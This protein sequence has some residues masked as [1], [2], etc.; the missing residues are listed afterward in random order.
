MN[1]LI[2]ENL[3][4]EEGHAKLVNCLEKFNIY[5]E[6]ISVLP[7]IDEVEFKTTDK[8]VFVFGSLKL[9]RLSKKYG[10]EPGA[11]ITDNHDY[12]VYSKYY[13]E[14]L[15]NYDSIVF[16]FGDDFEWEYDQQ[17]IRPCLDS[18]VFTGKVF[19]EEEWPAYRE[20]MLTNGHNTSLTKDTLIQV[21]K[22]KKLT[23][24]VRCWVV[25]DKVVTQSTYRRGSFL[26]Y[27]NIVD[28]DAIEFA[29]QM[30][31]I[32]QLAETFVIDVGLTS[33][34]WKIIECGSTSC[35]GFYDADMQKLIMALE[36]YYETK[37]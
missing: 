1:Y 17:F 32:F 9:A 15:L 20:R 8:N 36:D 33:E 4:R 24:E 6:L 18:K 5:Y 10:W 21:A 19:D 23:Q 34:G 13:K 37:R 3:F 26:V 25:N 12:N 22:P 11:L 27:D 2:Q 14:N 7:F 16:K 31:D 35:A 28:T 30:V 29:Q